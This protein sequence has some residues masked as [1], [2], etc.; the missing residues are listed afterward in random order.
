LELRSACLHS[1]FRAGLM[2]GRVRARLFLPHCSS[3]A[4]LSIHRDTCLWIPPHRCVGRR[5]RTHSVK[6]DRT[7]PVKGERH[8]GFRAVAPGRF[9]AGK[10]APACSRIAG[11]GESVMR[12]SRGTQ[13]AG[14]WFPG[15]GPAR[16]ASAR[17]ICIWRFAVA[18]PADGRRS[19]PRPNTND[20]DRG[21][22][23]CG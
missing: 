14:V 9:D 2:K 1:R 12:I 4:R 16:A 20:E 21:C 23:C 10:K 17:A 7:A 11:A 15:A 6:S 13:F 19:W 5:F 18:C 8:L 3:L 22:Q